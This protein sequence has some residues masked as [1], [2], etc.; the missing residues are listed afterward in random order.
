MVPPRLSEHLR[1][2]AQTGSFAATLRLGCVNADSDGAMLE[3]RLQD[4]WKRERANRERIR[5][6]LPP[7]WRDDPR[8]EMLAVCD[9]YVEAMLRAKHPLALARTVSQENPVT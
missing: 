1:S 5:T 2:V 8:P 3:L 4:H 6:A 7:S 9:V